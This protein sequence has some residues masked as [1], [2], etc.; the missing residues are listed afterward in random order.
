MRERQQEA[1]EQALEL[2][3][4]IEAEELIAEVEVETERE[5]DNSHHHRRRM[6]ITSSTLPSELSLFRKSSR[7]LATVFGKLKGI[8][9]HH[10]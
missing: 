7:N 4:D 5:P 1:I 3:L 10:E 6:I 2:E 8:Y 9:S